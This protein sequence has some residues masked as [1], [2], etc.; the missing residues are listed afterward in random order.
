MLK[1]IVLAIVALI[2]VGVATVAIVI[3]L[4]PAH[5]RMERSAVIAVP[6]NVAFTQVN[7]F[8]SW[9]AWSPWAKLD[10]DAKYTFDGEPA[11]KGAVFTWSGN[12]EVGEGRMEIIECVPDEL[13]RIKLDFIRP[14]EASSTS[15]FVF[16]A[17]GEQ[18]RVTWIMFGDNNY[19]SKA[20]YL[21]IDMDQVLGAEFDKGLAQMKA[22][23]E[24]SA[25]E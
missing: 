24:K 1:K 23:A 11:G 13:V 2:V 5:F 6:A 15:E 14:F 9:D 7:D 20:M 18:T 19:L 4:Q 21:F 22:V 8:H 3:A 16:K 25:K 17:A 10:P 12:S